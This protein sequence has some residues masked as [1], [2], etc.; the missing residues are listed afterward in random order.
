MPPTPDRQEQRYDKEERTERGKAVE[1]A[2]VQIEKQFGKG[3]IMRLGQNEKAYASLPTGRTPQG[4][5]RALRAHA[6]ERALARAR[7]RTHA[8]R[9]SRAVAEPLRG[10]QR[11]VAQP[12]RGE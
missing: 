8:L 4:M 3:S 11:A 12:H 1:L 10:T 9:R 5:Y 6:G 2:V 7:P